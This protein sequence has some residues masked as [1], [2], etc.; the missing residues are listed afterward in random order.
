MQT[1]IKTDKQEILVGSSVLK[2]KDKNF[3][4]IDYMEKNMEFN[5]AYRSYIAKNQILDSDRYVLNKFIQNYKEYRQSW[6][7]PIKRS[8]LNTPLSIDIETASVCNLACPHCSREYI[9]TPDKVMHEDLY[10]RLI[11]ETV[12]LNVPSIKLNWRGEPLLNPKLGKMIEYAK[13]QGILEVLINTNAV[14]LTE[15]KAEELIESGLDVIIY[16]F[17]GGTKKTYEKMR[18]GRFGE[19]NLKWC[20][21]I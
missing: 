12:S 16:S 13:E 7:N 18:P 3:N 14:S 20:T 8:N 19:N 9:I 15:E 10:K 1:S 11:Q 17:D 21:R 4:R 6:T 5:A 2:A